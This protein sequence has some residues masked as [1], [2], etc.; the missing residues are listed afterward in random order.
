VTEPSGAPAQTCDAVITAVR[1]FA[2][3]R[4]GGGGASPERESPSTVK[5]RY[6]QEVLVFD[7]ETLLDPAQRL[8][9]GVWRLYLDPPGKE[10][11]V[12]CTEEGFF[13]PDDLPADDPSGFAK[14]EAYVGDEKNQAD[15]AAGFP[16]RLKLWPLSRWIEERLWRCG[17]FHRRW[18]HVVGFNLPFDLG[19]VCPYWSPARG[20]YLGGWSLGLLGWFDRRGKWHDRRHARRLLMRA[21]DPRRT[22]FAWA[23]SG[24]G[25]EDEPEFWQPEA[26][27]VDLHTLVFAL[28]DEN[29]D[30]V[31]ACQA[32]GDGWT[33]VDVTYGKIT[34][35][36]LRYAREDIRHTAI[37]YRNCMAELR[38]HED[39]R[40]VPYALYSPATVGTEYLRAMGVQPPMRKF[41]LDERIYGWSMAAFFG[42]RAE[43]RI[44]RT[45]VPVT[46]VDAASMYPTVNALLGAWR[47]MVAERIDTVDATDEVRDLLADRHVV[48]R[49][50][51]RSFWHDEIGVTLVELA[52]SDGDVL[53]VRAYWDPDAQDPGIGVNPLRYR[54]TLWYMLPDV[55]ASVALSERVPDVARAIRLLPNGTQPGLRAV[56]LR[57]GPIVDPVGEGTDPFITMVQERRWVEADEGLPKEE[58]DR[59]GKFLKITANA[60]SYG[61]LARFDRRERSGTVNVFGPDGDPTERPVTAVE[62]PGPFCFPPVAAT[63]TAAA[64]LMLALLEREATRVGGTYAFCDTD[65][66]AIVATPRGASVPCPNADGAA[67]KALSRREVESILRRFDDLN[68][69]ERSLVPALWDAKHGSLD[70]PVTCFAISAKRY[71]LYRKTDGRVEFERVMDRHEDSAGSDEEAQAADLDGALEDWSEHGLG[72]YLDPRNPAAP[73]HDD[74]NRRIWM[75]E[76]WEW[77]VR[78][79]PLASMPEW[80]SRLALT[81]FTVS[82]PKLRAWFSGF[83]DSVPSR[84]RIRPGAF[85]LIGHPH[86]LVAGTSEARPARSYEPDPWR[87]EQGPWYDRRIGAEINVTTLS[88]TEDLERLSSALASGAVRLQTLADVLTRYRLHPEH[89]S[90]APDGRWAGEETRGLLQRRL[91]SSAPILTDLS[92]KEGNK[93]VERLSGEIESVEEYTTDY[94]ARADRWRTLVVPVLRQMREAIGTR[95]MS[96]RIGVHR[97][98]LERVLSAQDVRPHASTRK[99]YLDALHD[100][101]SN[102]LAERGW[103][104]GRDRTGTAWCYQEHLAQELVRTCRVCGRP[105]A[106]RLAL[107]CSEACKKMSYRRRR[108]SES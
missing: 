99:R 29:H 100:W 94:G 97:R 18:S 85:G 3:G 101:C 47:L 41:D 71:A 36:L 43:A 52:G 82:S 104:V 80:T 13:Y 58:R 20:Y 89:K 24:P 25:E 103:T 73:T 87:W 48:D 107:Y 9:V 90:L 22:L 51:D 21:I 92:G 8:L 17:W 53:P 31:R 78:D 54:G 15:T 6:G 83:D 19:R 1:V 39:V 56:K 45:P 96:D 10:P 69:Y 63:L 7:T 4:R 59:L 95:E 27:F 84:E 12:T 55:I 42:G 61:I 86:G 5:R 33:K 62:T 93:L 72:L 46:L 77:I 65:S 35:S 11:G 30:L 81:R 40:L 2:R 64:R 49:C 74:K 32:F 67:I 75:R 57:G 66:L 79:D 28:T 26:P 106:H 34:K 98:S 70:E 16:K 105:V 50:F 44:V 60:T 68:P 91:I 14:L 108:R 37:L 23:K 88:P 76:A 102:K 38:R